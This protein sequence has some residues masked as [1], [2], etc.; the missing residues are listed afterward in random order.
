MS[1]DPLT[2]NGVTSPTARPIDIKKLKVTDLKIELKNRGLATTGNKAELVERLTSAL[3]RAKTATTTDEAT[4]VDQV[5]ETL[6]W[7]RP[8]ENV[9][10]SAR[11][12]AASV[13]ISLKM[14]TKPYNAYHVLSG[15]TLQIALVS[16]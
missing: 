7:T 5:D 8:N 14:K 11:M 10:G 13:K 1:A 4:A 2:A 12:H 9:E 16:L 3:D 6:R 15:I